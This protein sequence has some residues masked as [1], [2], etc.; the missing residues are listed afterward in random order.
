MSNSTLRNIVL[1]CIFNLSTDEGIYASGKNE[2]YGCIFG[3]DSAITILKILKAI[4]NVN[5]FS[6]QE[7][8]LLFTICRR[9]LLT[10]VNLQGTKEIIESGEEPGKFIHEYRK[11]NYQRLLSLE[12][13]WYIYPDGIMRNFDSI[14]ST[15]LCLIAL[16][17]F[18]KLT[19]DSSFLMKILPAVDKGLTWIMEYGDKDHDY[20]LEYEFHKSRK[21]GGLRVQS[22]TDSHESLLSADGIFPV[23]PIAPVEVQGY[24]WLALRLWSNFYADHSSNYVRNKNYSQKLLQ[25]A[26][27]MKN[28]FNKMFLFKDQEYYFT[29]QAIN[30]HKQQIQ[31]IT[32]N[33][34]LLL[35]ASYSS[36]SEA[37]ESILSTKYV[38][39]LVNRSFQNDLFDPTAGIRTMSTRS[40]TFN[41]SQNSYHNGSFWPKLN[42]LSHEGLVKWKFSTHAR[43]LREATLTPIKYFESPIE[44]Y[45]KTQ[46]ATFIEYKSP[47]GQVSCRQQAWSAASIL[48]LVTN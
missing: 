6:S 44:L 36:E 15:P 32:G 35:W 29:A 9:S 48:D 31:T 26:K 12:N 7:R 42:G 38:N 46:D 18:W 25:F 39:D 24:A 30:G 40:E 20:L 43:L 33:P 37:T 41:G 2:V 19:E 47:T 16:Y 27:N 28:T 17:R 10:L 8:E 5:A 13:P 4:Q 1:N 22:W 11:N 14:D 3:R 23:Y 45:I 34:L 21:F